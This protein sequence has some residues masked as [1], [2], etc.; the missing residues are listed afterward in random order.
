[1]EQTQGTEPPNSTQSPSDPFVV[2]TVPPCQWILYSYIGT[3]RIRIWDVSILIPNGLFLLFLVFYLREAVGKL[4]VSNSPVFTA[5]YGL[6]ICVSV[7]SVLRCIVSM[8]VNS[9]LPVGDYTDKALWLV[10]RFFLLATELSVV[11]FGVVFGH[12]DSRTSIQRILIL[13]F[14]I[15][16]IY[17][18]VQGALEFEYCHPNFSTSVDC[19]AN[20]SSGINDSYDLFAHGG[21]IFLFTTSVFFFLVYTIIVLLPFT[22]LRDRF[23]LPTK[24]LFY[25]Y[26]ASLACLNLC[27]AIG[28]MLLYEGVLP[29][30]C[31]VDATTYIYFSIFNPLV[32]VVFLWNF[33]KVTQAGIQFSYKHQEDELDD[34][35]VSLPYS[36][37]ANKPDAQTSM[38]S[39]DSTHFDVQARRRSSS[40]DSITNT[41][42]ENI[43]GLPSKYSVNSDLYDSGALEV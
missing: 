31:V 42:S 36:N 38:Y 5:F 29:S 18:V 12:L 19:Y 30:L 1:M 6:V 39:F 26:C 8:T 3:S 24:R 2:V 27:Q 37:G 43:A 34:E 17:S 14:T 40:N 22:K 20:S 21:M 7:I 32:Y 11:V 35:Q 4:K 28:S 9:E 13:T 33:F 16:L 23:L 15:A 25:Y 10:L 41:A